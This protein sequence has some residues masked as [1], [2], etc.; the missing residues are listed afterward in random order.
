M[1]IGFTE[2]RLERTRRLKN[3]RALV[4]IYSA[5]NFS[6][7][8]LSRIFFVGQ[9][10]VWVQIIKTT[11]YKLGSKIIVQVQKFVFDIKG[12]LVGISKISI[13]L[14]ASIIVFTYSGH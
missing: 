12:I 8:S 6:W 1:Y 3:T 5:S 11:F 10:C 14:I 9:D 2:D 13:S 4:N 7:Y